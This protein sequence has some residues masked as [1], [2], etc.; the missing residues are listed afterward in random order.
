[1]RRSRIA[2]MFVRPEGQTQARR[3]LPAEAQPPRP[4]GGPVEKPAA[5]EL[6][7]QEQLVR[8]LEM[9]QRLGVVRASAL[10]GPLTPAQ[11]HAK[12][13]GH[14]LSPGCCRGSQRVDLIPWS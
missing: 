8:L 2:L 10:N 3:R 12:V 5:R 7:R 13:T 14:L 11:Q 6:D 9:T 4:S 1:M